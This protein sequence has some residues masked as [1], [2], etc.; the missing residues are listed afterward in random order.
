[1]SVV[2]NFA[3]FRVSALLLIESLPFERL[4]CWPWPFARKR[5][6]GPGALAGDGFLV[7]PICLL[8]FVEHVGGDVAEFCCPCFR[9]LSLTVEGDLHGILSVQSLLLLVCPSNVSRRI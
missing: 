9:R 4:P 6:M 1:M 2:K 8:S 3:G 5:L 7:G